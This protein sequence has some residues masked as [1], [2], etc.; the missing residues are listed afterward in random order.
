MIGHCDSR[1]K[2][3]YVD[4]KEA[5]LDLCEQLRGAAA[6]ALDTEFMREKTFY[7]QLAL[8]QITDGE[9][10]ACVD[11]LTIDD[12]GPLMDIIYD[13]SIEKV[14]HAGRQDLE[15]FFDLRGEVPKPVYD[16]QI[17][18]TVL[19][20]GDQV[21]YAA[22]VR[23]TLGVEL[24][25]IHTRTNWAQRPLDS[26]QVQYA[27]D[28]VR[29]LLQVWQR[30]IGQL[31]DLGRLSWL[32][33]D[34]Q[35]LTARHHYDRNPDDCWRRIRGIRVLKGQQLA[36]LRELA[37]WREQQAREQNKPRKWVLR[38]DALVD[39]SRR[40]PDSQPAMKS[41][42]SLEPAVIKRHGEVILEIINQGRAAPQDRWPSLGFRFT[43]TQG[44]EALI[45]IMMAMVRQCGIDNSVS[46]S[47]LASR[48]D[49]EQ[50]VAGRED[51]MLRQ[52]WRY[53]LLGQRLQHFLSGGISLR[54][55][56]GRLC[57]EDQS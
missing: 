45:D 20:L 49:L 42:R 15:I 7:A 19:G 56:D 34:F 41:L 37:A 57:I 16:T 22:L 8:L 17:G 14:M 53:R 29:Y 21:S 30:Q 12:L 48:R 35:D 6:I 39:L 23:D 3:Y 51:V 25:K 5:L 27:L 9:V 36:V 10:I 46:P 55:C 4:N 44:Q 31:T 33:D 2:E 18:A 52:G 43:P 1:M 50:L 54:V 40:M 24:D 11:P 32:Q 28:D 38:D 47:V 13:E 26:G